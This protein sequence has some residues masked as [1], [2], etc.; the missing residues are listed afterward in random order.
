MKNLKYLTIS[1]L[2]LMWTVYFLFEIF[3][4]RVTDMPTV[5]G[6]ILLILLFALVGLY[7]HNLSL[8]HANGFKN[9]TIINI[10]FLLMIVDQGC[11]I[12]IKKF[13]FTSYVEIIKGFL[14]FNPIINKDGSWLNARF[15]TSISFPL[16]ITINFIALIIFFEL[17][18]YYTHK[19]N[20]NFYGDMCFL[21]IFSGALCSLIDKVFYGGSLDFIGISNLFIA[22]IKDIYINIGILFFIISIVISGYLTE[23]ENTSFKEDIDSIKKFIIF[24]KND[25]LSLLKK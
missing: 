5:L 14:S 23:E 25:L 24:A 10:F 20:K 11:K 15:G 4:G 13:F 18:R 7:F 21:F 17:Y 6:N 16:L 1:V 22:D 9:K 12:I 2:P 19:G 3:T 8:R